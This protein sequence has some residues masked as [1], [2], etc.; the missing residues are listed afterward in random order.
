M[1]RAA[2][3]LAAFAC[4]AAVAVFA[5]EPEDAA[6]IPAYSIA[7]LKVLDGSV[8]VRTE[9]NGDWEEFSTNS[10]V[11]PGSRIS[12]PASSEGE[13][14]FHGGQYLLLTS[15]TDL[16]VREL[17]EGRS[18]FRIRS[19]E[20][21]F[22]LPPDDFAPVTV[23]VPGSARVHV[24][25]PGKYWVVVDEKNRTNLVVRSG[26]ATVVKDEGEVRVR[27]GEQA[28]IGEEVRV[29]RYGDPE[30]QAKPAFPPES[31][32]EVPVP[33]SVTS[34]LQDYGEWVSVSGY[35]Y[36]WRPYVATG[37]TPYVY[38]RWVWISPYGWTW[39]SYEPWGWYPY[40]CGYWVT[41]PAFGWVWYP[42]NA[43]FTVGVGVPWTPYYGYRRYPYY[44]RNAYYYPANVRFVPEGG[45]VRWVPLRPGERYRPTSVR[46]TDAS[47]ARWDR[48]L[49]RGSVYVRAGKD[50]GQTRDYV[51]VRTERQAELRRTLP[52]RT[53]TDMRPVRPE[54]TIQEGR[55]QDRQAT[56]KKGRETER[57]PAG[58]HEM[59]GKPAD[60]K[61]K[62]PSGGTY[63]PRETVPEKGRPERGER[64]AGT[65]PAVPPATGRP[66]ASVA[67]PAA[68]KPPRESGE[69]VPREKSPAVLPQ[70]VRETVEKPPALPPPRVRESVPAPQVPADEGPVVVPAVPDAG[71]GGSRGGDG[72]SRGGGGGS[73]DGGRGGG[74][75]GRTR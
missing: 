16:E 33:P 29:S 20:I 58:R 24:P 64:P 15:G 41:I 36:V 39:V 75:S 21:R 68:V 23:R 53:R 46:R 22:D 55:P 54:R 30:P 52:Q 9:A 70:R 37:W 6:G 11:P 32:A 74:G 73:G 26:E 25:V 27:G 10:P 28:L 42:Y 51:A 18:V 17:K 38:G 34:E 1:R 60:G 19:G 35:G 69:A 12:V 44:Y 7:R 63:I 5:G 62:A 8:W 50:G 31:G 71:R 47:F 72:G 65:A 49:E 61:T 4:F 56:P 67:P 2:G 59:P 45:Q 13:L 40:R 48:P 66:P 3:F 14:Q 57:R 43:F